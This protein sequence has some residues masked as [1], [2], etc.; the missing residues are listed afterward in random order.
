MFRK[1]NLSLVI[2]SDVVAW[3]RTL[4]KHHPQ[5]PAQL[6]S[7]DDSSFNLYR[8]SISVSIPLGNATQLHW[9]NWESWETLRGFAHKNLN[10]Y[11]SQK[12]L[13]RETEK[14]ES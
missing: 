14:F 10:L 3:S 12:E 6:A 7:Q 8:V 4:E 5:G 1:L 11:D 9:A 2:S 13:V